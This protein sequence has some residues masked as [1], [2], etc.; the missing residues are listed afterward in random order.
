MIRQERAPCLRRRRAPAPNL[1]RHGR[2]T[3]VDTQLQQFAM[4]P[5]RAPARVRLR[6]RANQRPDVGG[7]SRSPH[8]TSAPPGPPQS[9]A[10]PVPGDD[11]LRADNYERRSPAA[12]EARELD[13]E[14]TVRLR[15]PQSSRS[16]S[17]EHLQLVPKCQYFELERGARTCPCSERHEKGQEHR[18]HRQQRNH[19]RPQHQLLQQERTF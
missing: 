9:E 8:A 5:R 7:H 13:P 19:R 11:G 15:E 17:L 10:S 12:P 4:N 2:L 14:P 18:R 16:G 6:H 3:N 1:F